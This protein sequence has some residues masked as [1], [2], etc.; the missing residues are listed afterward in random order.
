MRNNDYTIL[1]CDGECSV[2]VVSI[3]F[4]KSRV[5]G[6]SYCLLF[7]RLVDAFRCRFLDEVVI[8]LRFF[9]V[10][11]PSGA[12]VAVR[13]FSMSNDRELCVCIRRRQAQFC[14]N[15]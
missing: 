11:L 3:L 4:H 15:V 6:T 7:R 10:C 13:I 2:S 1:Q 14:E 5:G 12:G 9:V 8:L